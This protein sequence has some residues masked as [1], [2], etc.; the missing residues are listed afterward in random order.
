MENINF[1]VSVRCY[2]YNQSQYI[3]DAMDGFAMQQT[4]FPYI[5]CI[6]DDCSTDGEQNVIKQYMK[7]NFFCEDTINAYKEETDYAFIHFAKHKENPNCFFVV[8]YLK[9]NLYSKREGYKKKQ[10]LSRWTKGCDYEAL[11]EGDDYWINPQKLQMQV[12]FLDT[13]IEYSFCH[14]GFNI[15]RENE[16]KMRKG[17]FKKSDMPFD[18]AYTT[19]L[20]TRNNCIGTAT[21]CYR[22][23]VYDK[24]PHYWRGKNW[25][26]GDY[27]LWIELSH[28]NK[29]KYFP[30][31]TACYRVLTHSASHSPNINRMISFKNDSFAVRKLYNDKFK[32]R[33]DIRRDYTFLMYLAY[34]YK[35]KQ[36]AEEIKKITPKDRIG[37]K[38]CIYYWATKN[39]VLIPVV[40]ISKWLLSKRK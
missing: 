35:D 40:T 34:L 19:Y 24:C 18:D 32:M 30:D 21:V 13:H 1:K 29:V 33:L 4:R 38:F 3:T 2:T 9:E 15:R 14:T 28:G 16:L 10:Y 20:L 8:L 22:C 11:C 7:E 23:S 17:P 36:K 27:P 5:C 37:I 6:V 31:I 26:M 12:D 25:A 39:P